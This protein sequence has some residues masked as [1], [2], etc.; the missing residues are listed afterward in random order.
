MAAKKRKEELDREIE[1]VKKEY[2]ERMSKKK[3][4]QDKK[5]KEAEDK[6]RKKDDGDDDSKN[7]EKER[8]EKVCPAYAREAIF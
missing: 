1:L 4:G 3:K 8:D 6:E 5:G 2:E 7:V